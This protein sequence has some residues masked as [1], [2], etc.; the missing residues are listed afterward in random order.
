M[1]EVPA[2]GDVETQPDDEASDPDLPGWQFDGQQGSQDHIG[3]GQRIQQGNGGGD[4]F[5][6][7]GLEF[8]VHHPQQHQAGCQDAAFQTVAGHSPFEP[9]HIEDLP[10]KV[11]VGG[12]VDDDHHSDGDQERDHVQREYLQGQGGDGSADQVIQGHA[13]NPVDGGTVDVILPVQFPHHII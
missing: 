13:G 7:G 2:G 4:G 8:G 3:D 5:L 12:Q 6:A 9:V 11:E 1:P 10:G